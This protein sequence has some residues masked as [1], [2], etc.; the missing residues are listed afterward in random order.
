MLR[1]LAAWSTRRRVG[2]GGRV[3]FDC[4]R[5]GGRRPHPVRWRQTSAR[6]PADARS[7]EPPAS[8]HDD[9]DPAPA[10]AHRPSHV[11]LDLARLEP[12]RP[13]QALDDERRERAPLRPPVDAVG[14]GEEC[15]GERRVDGGEVEILR[16]RARASGV[17][18][19]ESV[20]RR[21]ERT[22]RSGVARARRTSRLLTL[23]SDAADDDNDA[24]PLRL[25]TGA[26]RTPS[27]ES[28]RR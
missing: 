22:W 15:W 27:S 28:A 19:G 8:L 18:E 1:N 11:A 24:P 14:R 4:R 5:E 25:S 17:R 3:T 7:A 2:G 21:R 10:V 9:L 13:A 20:Q 26:K 12:I 6:A 23:A 16:T